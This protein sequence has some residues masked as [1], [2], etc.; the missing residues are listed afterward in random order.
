MTRHDRLLKP[1]ETGALPGRRYL[2][3][4]PLLVAGAVALAATSGRAAGATGEAPSGRAAIPDVT[5]SC[6]PTLQSA[7]KRV[8]ARFTAETGAPVHVF[9][10]PPPL[11]VAQLERDVQIDILLTLAETLDDAA[12]RGVVQPT[13][14]VAGWRNRLVVASLAEHAP[15][16]ALSDVSGVADL[17]GSGRFAVTDPTI[18]A[19]IDGPAVL[20]RLGLRTKLA[21]RL[22]GAANSD[23]VV[24]L[25]TSRTARF[26]L[27]HVTDVRADP[28][29]QVVAMV[30]LSAHAPIVYAAAA[31]SVMKSP[32]TE[33]FL[34]FLV[35]GPAEQALV[36]A[37]LVR[38]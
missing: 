15:S 2:F 11:L 35:S 30:P 29:L 10:A 19:T 37:G 6:D 26:G 13:T 9:S 27:V 36:D 18:A 32:N 20:D 16:P 17:L 8:G 12:R 38:T 28:R 22:I 25:L 1:T 24:F 3:R 14:R 33:N 4:L 7:V 5:I 21:E 31:T 34:H 23:E